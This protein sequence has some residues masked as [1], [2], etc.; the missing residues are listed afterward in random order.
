M[1]NNILDYIKI[2]YSEII[3]VIFGV[4]VAL[5]LNRL[6][7]HFNEVNKF[8][9]ML[10]MIAGELTNNIDCLKHKHYHGIS[11]ETFKSVEGNP[12][13]ISFVKAH[14]HDVLWKTYSILREYK[15][16]KI[17][18]KVSEDNE[19]NQLW[20]NE[21]NINNVLEVEIKMIRG[22]KIKHLAFYNKSS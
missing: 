5:L 11:F 1:L 15:S 16:L 17:S 6:W 18:G 12:I 21:T 14:L 10:E 13:F 2:N 8:N 9:R 19:L 7:S 3:N 4:I 20:F 22:S